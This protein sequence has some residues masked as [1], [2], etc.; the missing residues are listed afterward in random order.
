MAI[1]VEDRCNTG[2][3]MTV[4]FVLKIYRLSIVVHCGNENS[5]IPP[6]RYERIMSILYCLRISLKD[7]GEEEE[8]TIK[9][10]CI[11]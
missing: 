8:Y 9:S 2:N 4:T 10:N 3:D 6:M 7:E 5:L 11:C 1:V